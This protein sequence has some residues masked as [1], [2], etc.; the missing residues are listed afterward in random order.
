M[1]KRFI[2]SAF[3]PIPKRKTPQRH[4][5]APKLS[6]RTLKQARKEGI[7]GL[8]GR[9]PFSGPSFIQRSRE[10]SSEQKA[11]WH[12][13]TGAGRSRVIREFFGLTDEEQK[14]VR[15]ALEHEM[16]TR[17]QGLSR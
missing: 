8:K 11:M 15:D 6:P 12:N 9:P 7:G 4:T 14:Q 5:R 3:A 17:F 10:V 13:V 16:S 1:A 2:D